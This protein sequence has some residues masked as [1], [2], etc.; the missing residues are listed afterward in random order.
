M[1]YS[2][3]VSISYSNILHK[4]FLR[5]LEIQTPIDSTRFPLVLKLTDGL[6]GSGSH[7]I[8]NQLQE[9]ANLSTKTY[10]LFAFK[11][12]TLTDKALVRPGQTLPPILH[13]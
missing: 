6:D 2:I 4:T 3:R 5:L 10:I 12:L 7:R 1:G 8:Y 13:S 9:N 11:M